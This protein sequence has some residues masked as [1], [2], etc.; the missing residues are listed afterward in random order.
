MTE[1][2]LIYQKW[3]QLNVAFS[4]GTEASMLRIKKNL[5]QLIAARIADPTPTN[6]SGLSREVLNLINFYF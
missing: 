2:F 5:D 1:Y 6:W 3:K 4:E